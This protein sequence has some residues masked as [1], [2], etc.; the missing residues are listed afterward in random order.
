MKMFI[1]LIYPF[2]PLVF[3]QSSACYVRAQ[4]AVSVNEDKSGL[5]ELC[6][7]GESLQ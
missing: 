5:S 6:P 7:F 1:D 4:L 2:N 3:R